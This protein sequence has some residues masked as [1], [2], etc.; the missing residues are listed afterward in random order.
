MELNYPLGA[1]ALLIALQTPAPNGEVGIPVFI[2]GKPGVGKS[3]FIEALAQ[4][5]FPVLTLV[6]S[7]HDPTDF[8]GLPV[9]KDD[10]VHYAPPAWLDLFA[11]HGQGILFL[12]ELTTAPPSVQAAL[13][14]V[15]LERRIGF[16]ALPK[17]VR[18]VAAANPTDMMV[19]GWELSP[20][21]RNRFVHIQWDLPLEV[22]VVGLTD[23]FVKGTLSAISAGQ[24]QKLLVEWK[25]KIAAFL[26][27]MPEALHGNM[28]ESRFAF[29]SPRSW[30][31]LAALLA[32]C[33]ILDEVPTASKAPSDTCLQ[34]IKGC[35]GEGLAVPIVNFLQELK[36]P[37]PVALLNGEVQVFIPDLDDS[38]LF[39]LFNGLVRELEQRFTSDQLLASGMIFMNLTERV[40]ADGRQDVVYATLRNICKKGLLTKLMAKAQRSSPEDL[41]RVTELIQ[42]LFADKGLVAFIDVFE[43]PQNGK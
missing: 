17:G 20:P 21:L 33:E 18:V 10:K 16:H 43:Q 40:F 4:P 23:G 34:L 11:Q 30:D 3:S 36:L 42:T 2:W 7:I 12:D 27:Q 15:V 39:V 41:N 32:T 14:R 35:I 25:T 28:E 13:L 26:Q 24:H 37:N 5:D 19:G 9:F 6:A 1:R 29:A 38:A 8:S 22:F 31:N